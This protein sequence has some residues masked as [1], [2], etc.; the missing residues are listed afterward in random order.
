MKKLLFIILIVPFFILPQS[1]GNSGLSF[2]KL[3]FG[4]R[5]VAM[6]DAGNAISDDVTTLFY[7]P[8]KLALN[9]K[10][11]IMLMHNEWIQDVRSEILGVRSSVFGIPF[12]FGFNV[13]SVTGIEARTIPGEPEST[14]D[15][16]YFFGS[17][18][19]GYKFNEY[20]STGFTVKYLYEGLIADEANGWGFDLGLTYLTPLKGLTASAVVRNLGGMNALRNEKTTL[21]TELRA[22][23]SYLFDFNDSHFQVIAGTELMTYTST[24]DIH[25]NIGA[26]I[27]YD[28][29]IALRGGY[30]SGFESRA[31]TGGIGI[32]WGNL[33]FDYALQPFT[34]GLGTA[35]LFS[36]QF[37]F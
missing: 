2:L 13:T 4:A 22:G 12:A 35:N 3:G 23:G 8:A 18:S 29:V 27:M 1:A 24:D 19:T 33:K 34:Y 16:N 30:Q 9:P 36:L 10:S 14:F 5:N 37:S 32:K 15:A 26:E 28:E 7:N 21:P 20:F 31:F 11:E 17:L 25:I 6:G